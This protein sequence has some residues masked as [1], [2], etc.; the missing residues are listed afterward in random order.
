[1]KRYTLD[2]APFKFLIHIDAYRLEKPEE[3]S[4]LGWEELIKNPENLIAL[5]WADRVEE[6]LPK[7][8]IRVHFTFI[9]EHTREIS[10]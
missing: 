10:L 3:L 6:L 7:D 8:C 1:M 4:V 5:E 2:A 9:D